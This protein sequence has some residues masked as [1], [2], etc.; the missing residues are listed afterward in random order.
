MALAYS[1]VLV[2][3]GLFDHDR[4]DSIRHAQREADKKFEALAQESRKTLVTR[5]PEPRVM[6][7][8]ELEKLLPG[9]GPQ[10]LLVVGLYFTA[11][12]S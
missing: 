11:E 9:I 6:T 2:E 4:E 8:P 12:I 5:D 1:V 10:A 7:V 3:A